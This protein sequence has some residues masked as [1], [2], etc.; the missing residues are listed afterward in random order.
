LRTLILDTG[1][2]SIKHGTVLQ[3]PKSQSE[4]QFDSTSEGASIP[5]RDSNSTTNPN[6]NTPSPPQEPSQSPN[7]SAKAKHQLATLLSDQINTIHNKSQLKVT[8]PQERGYTTDLGVQFQIWGH[9]LEK[10]GFDCHHPYSNGG[11]PAFFPSISNK[12]KGVKNSST[13]KKRNVSSG[14]PVTEQQ[15]QTIMTHAGSILLLSQPFTPRCILERE[16]EVWFRDF[17]FGRVARRLG[18]CCSAYRYLRHLCKVK[19]APVVVSD[20]DLVGEATGSGGLLGTTNDNKVVQSNTGITSSST[21]TTS[22]SILYNNGIIDDETGCCCVV[23]CGFSLTH[24][25]PTYEGRAIEIAIRRINIGGKLL[26]NHLK[27]L[28]SYRQWNMMDEFFIVNE[29]KESL[30]FVSNN[31]SKE[32]KD[33]RHCREGARWFDRNFVL[34]DFV[35]TFRGCIRLPRVLQME[36]DMEE[37]DGEERR[38]REKKRLVEEMM[39]SSSETVD[40]NGDADANTNDGK[41]GE[42]HIKSKNYKTIQTKNMKMT[43]TTMMTAIPI[44]KPTTRY[45]DESSNNDTPK[46]CDEN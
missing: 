21:T 24:I 32:I 9:V 34:P 11:V 10:E 3:Q 27:E 31:F 22:D 43:T 28:I 33:A 15:Q 41:V 20:D 19:D 23:D 35:E 42:H 5:I 40:E 16:D 17:G 30:C 37:W 4:L 1:G 44:T 45:V 6:S 25:V 39:G 2:W 13:K 14:I 18:Q 46:Y 29:V 26:T 12:K 38:K 36:K 7:L 8:F